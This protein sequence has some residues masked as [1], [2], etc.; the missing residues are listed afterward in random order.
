MSVSDR[1][2]ILVESEG[3]Q[4]A[5]S[6]KTGVKK[7]TLNSVLVKGTGLRSQTLD[8]I[9]RAYPNLNLRWLIIG[10]G[11]MWVTEDSQ[12]EKAIAGRDLSGGESDSAWEKLAAAQE[13]RIKV[14]EAYIKKNAPESMEDLGIE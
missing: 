7:G 4:V 5:F 2:K 1:L 10:D 6:R 8:E 12:D 13:K 11:E 3:S 9:G 14:L